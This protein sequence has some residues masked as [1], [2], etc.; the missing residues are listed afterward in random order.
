MPFRLDLRQFLCADVP[1]SSSWR[2]Q[3][4]V[5]RFAAG[6][7]SHAIDSAK[8]RS[9]VVLRQ[10]AEGIARRSRAADLPDGFVG[11]EAPRARRGVE[12]VV[13]AGRSED[14]RP[15]DASQGS[16]SH[17]ERPLPAEFAAVDRPLLLSEGPPEW[18]PSGSLNAPIRTR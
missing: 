15:V 13:R 17:R 16:R 3:P 6:V 5:V 1:D 7:R 18:A 8:M 4:S 9:R 2:L 12:G 10:P 11:G 14:D